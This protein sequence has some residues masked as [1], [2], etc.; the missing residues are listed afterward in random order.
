MG[1]WC[2][3]LPVH[4]PLTQGCLGICHPCLAQIQGLH[5]SFM[6]QGAKSAAHSAGSLRQCSA[7][8]AGAWQVRPEC[9]RASLLG[10]LGPQNALNR[11]YLQFTRCNGGRGVFTLCGSVDRLL[12]MAG[13]ISTEQPRVTLVLFVYAVDAVTSGHV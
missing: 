1:I 5:G 2:A 8:I 13:T 12:R 7:V 10:M 3:L 11:Q 6:R 9:D 4:H